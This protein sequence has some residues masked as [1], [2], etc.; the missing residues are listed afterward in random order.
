MS[1]ELAG[2]NAA[3]L[4]LRILAGE[5]PETIA[6]LPVSSNE[7]VVDGR[8]LRRWGLDEAALPGGTEVRYRDPGLWDLYRWQIVGA[9]AL[10]ILETTLIVALIVQMARRR[11][12]EQDLRMSQVELRRLTGRL[13]QAQEGESRRIARELHDDLGQGLAL[14]TVQ[15]DLLRQKPP[16]AAGQLGTR[17]QELL[18]QVRQ[19]SS[20]VH[21]LSHQLH[22]AKLEQLG[23][24]AAIRGL[25][26]ELTHR[27]GV[28][29]EFTENRMPP[30]IPP[31]TALCL[32]RIA[33]EGL[34]NAIKH[35]GAQHVRVELSGSVEVISQWII[36]D[37]AG[38]DTKLIQGN[39]GGLGLVSMRERVFSLGGE[40]AIDSQPSEGTQ[41]Y[42]RIPLD[43]SGGDGVSPS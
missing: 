27:H 38:F 20:S 42:V 10:F 14:L 4:A 25:C 13:L 5:R 34:A 7:Y 39:G 26:H 43:R 3:S 21:E 9:I 8:Q 32:Y 24:S 15:M 18:R 28:K 2:K 11:K 36:D 37:G 1:F 23:L 19:L 41:I 35:S 33:Q 30:E 12:A 40:I 6:G 16:E 22:P 29:I 17:M 31:A